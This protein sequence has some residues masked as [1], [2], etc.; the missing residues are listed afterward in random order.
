MQKILFGAL[1]LGLMFVGGCATV[2]TNYGE[3]KKAA[4]AANGEPSLLTGTRLPKPTTER[5]LKAVGNNEY[6]E[7]NPH[8]SI[9]NSAAFKKGN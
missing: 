3:A 1:V 2:D 4:A 5:V 9:G 6:N 7:T 8:T